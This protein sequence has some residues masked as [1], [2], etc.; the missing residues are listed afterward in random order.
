MKAGLAS[1]E[2][3]RRRVLLC[4]HTAITMGLTAVLLWA[5]PSASL[6]EAGSTLFLSRSAVD[7]AWD[8]T[9]VVIN[10]SRTPT[11]AKL[12]AYDEGGSLLSEASDRFVLG[13]G[14]RRVWSQGR[15]AFPE[16]SAALRVES[17]GPLIIYL[18]I[19][20]RD[21]SG[22][23]AILPSLRPETALTFPMLGGIK[24]W[25]NQLSLLNT[26]VATTRPEV[27]AL[28][29]DGRVLGSRLLPPLRSMGSHTIMIGELFDSPILASL[30][31]IRIVADQPLSGLQVFGSE[32]RVDVAA[33]TASLDL[34]REF[35]LPVFQQQAGVALWSVVGFLNP[36]D[37]PASV[38]VEAF[39]SGRTS[40]GHL[41]S[42]TSLPGFASHRLATTNISGSLP[43]GTAFLKISASEPI[44]AYIVIGSLD[45]QGLTAVGA[46]REN[47][48]GVGYDLIGSGDGK[49]L[50][51]I[52]TIV[53]SAG[54]VV[55]TLAD[56][57]R[58][59]WKSTIN[60]GQASSW[61]VRE[62]EHQTSARTKVSVVPQKRCNLVVSGFVG[63]PHRAPRRG[64]TIDLIRGQ[65]KIQSKI[66]D[67]KGKYSFKGLC[68][69]DTL[70]PTKDGY[71]FSRGYHSCPK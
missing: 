61:F 53:D 60:L 45:S 12:L 55:V 30:A 51:A 10:L 16:R 54:G 70:T 22:L 23:E 59:Y 3:H 64:V 31:I 58:G 5:M 4:R 36:G 11:N 69:N 34:G 47:E 1:S 57:K 26:G 18:Q 21:G 66:T 13:P 39:D 56:A 19:E 71:T 63:L 42:F 41:S 27:M 17:D 68:P 38:T 20:P 8:A 15:G 35:F 9:V 43:V 6:G 49:V 37:G 25:W 14:E 46:L 52:P 62:S 67:A 65:S 33:L 40:L 44:S 2:R 50:A 48:S 28:D 24:P 29:K 7:G 32:D